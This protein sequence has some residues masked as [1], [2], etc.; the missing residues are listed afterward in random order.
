MTAHYQRKTLLF[1]CMTALH[2]GKTLLFQCTTVLY[3]RKALQSLVT[4]RLHPRMVVLYQGMTSVMPQT[5]H[6]RMPG[7]SP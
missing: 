2:Q 7:F 1:Q 6:H 4:D 5:T 3:Q